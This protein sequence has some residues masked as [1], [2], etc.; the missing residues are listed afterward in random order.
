MIYVAQY[1]IGLNEVQIPP[2]IYLKLTTLI[3]QRFD[4]TTYNIGDERI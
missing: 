4:T 2:L 1:S 3:I